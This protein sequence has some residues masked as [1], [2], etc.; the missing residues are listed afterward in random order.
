MQVGGKCA[1]LGTMIQAGLPVPPGFAVTTAAF[2]HMGEAVDI[3]DPYVIAGV[4]VPMLW[5][6]LCYADDSLDALVARHE[7]A[8]GVQ[9]LGPRAAQRVGDPVGPA[10]PGDQ[11]AGV[12]PAHG[13]DEVARLG[14]LEG[15]R[16]SLEQSIER[17]A[18]KPVVT[19]A[20]ETPIWRSG[21]NTRSSPM[22]L[23]G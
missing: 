3:A 8:A 9:T 19:D 12:E 7:R 23:N 2:D 15:G 14:D 4:N 17:F 21:F 1:S 16:L 22:W 11:V 13:P 10:Q 6:S 5:R 18:P 20:A